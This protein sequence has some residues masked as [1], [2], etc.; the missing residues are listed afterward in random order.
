VLRSTIRSI[1][2]GVWICILLALPAARTGGQ[3][4]AELPTCVNAYA[5]SLPM[6]FEILPVAGATHVSDSLGAYT[7]SRTSCL[8]VRDDSTGIF[9]LGS[10]NEREWAEC[11]A[12]KATRSWTLDLSHPVAGGGG[13]DRGKLRSSG[14]HVRIVVQ[15]DSLGRF[16]GLRDLKIGATTEV[17]YLRLVNERENRGQVIFAPTSP[18]CS[19]YSLTP[20][21]TAAKIRR[22]S[23]TTWEVDLPPGSVGRLKIQSGPLAARELVDNG[24]Y[25]FTARYRIESAR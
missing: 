16:V 22:T 1:R 13:V 23:A 21:T 11:T 24:L 3:R 25:H 5:A 19:G 10:P 8:T 4:G 14:M 18:G 6:R 12:D 2:G 20:G 15:K 17:L 7:E 9:Y